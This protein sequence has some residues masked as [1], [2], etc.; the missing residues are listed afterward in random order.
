MLTQGTGSTLGQALSLEIEKNPQPGYDYS[1]A[2][3]WML[4]LFYDAAKDAAATPRSSRCRR[5]VG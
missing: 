1:G 3:A 2:D 5:T 4:A